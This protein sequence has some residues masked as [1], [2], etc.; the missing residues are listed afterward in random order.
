MDHTI[1]WRRVDYPGHEICHLS[2]HQQ[3]KKLCGTSIMVYDGA[4]CKL[5]YEVRCDRN[6]QT[7]SASVGG[8]IGDQLINVRIK[9]K[10]GHW[11]L[12][13][14]K[15]PHLIDCIDIDLGFTP[16]TNLLPIR[17]LS[18]NVDEK[19]DIQ[20]AWLTFPALMFKPLEQRYIKLDESTYQYESRG[21]K[22]IRKIKVNEAGLVTSYPGFWEAEIV[23][24]IS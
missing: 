15:I 16:A 17:R 18:L 13:E 20:S 3:E 8:Q 22:F 10:G 4:P 23:P 24:A 2:E 21:G 1:L 6:W 5:N 11:W 12:N 9:Q 14:E 7:V 19:M